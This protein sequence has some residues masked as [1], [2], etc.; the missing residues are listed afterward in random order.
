MLKIETIKILKESLWFVFVAF[1]LMLIYP[2]LA[3]PNNF[4]LKKCNMKTESK[5]TN[6]RKKNEK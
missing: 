5:I 6:K 1:I 2:L 3:Q 4:L